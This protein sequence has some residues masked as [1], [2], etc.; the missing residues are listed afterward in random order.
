MIT[1]HT[2]IYGIIGDPISQVRAPEVFN[3]LFARNN[4][5]AVFVPMQVA[6]EGLETAVA[7]FRA[8][9]NLIGF[10]ATVPHKKAMASLCDEL[11]EA[12]RAIGAVNVV[13]REA[14]G[15]LIGNMYDGAGFVA[16]LRKQGHDPSGCRALLLGAGGAA[17]AI[18]FALA[19]AGGASLLISNRTPSKA[20]EIV[21]RIGNYFPNRRIRAGA[22]DPTGHDLV[23]NATS[24]GMKATDPLPIDPALLAPNMTVAE[25]IMKPEVTPILAAAKARGCA[26]HYGRHMLDEQVA[27]WMGH[28]LPNQVAMG[29]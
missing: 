1:E 14:D 23:I 21:A 6:P 4:Y 16:G 20:E 29:T 22:P 18:A 7:S 11:G 28:W 27:M 8:M 17:A 15:R 3:E 19:E 5:D 2:K 13:R 10:A 9:E 25:I 26:V 12:S 24:L